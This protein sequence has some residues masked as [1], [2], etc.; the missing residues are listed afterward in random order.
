MQVV[1]C[2]ELSSPRSGNNGVPEASVLKPLLFLI[3]ITHVSA[4][5]YITCQ[6]RIFGDDLKLYLHKN[7]NPNIDS[8]LC[9]ILNFPTNINNLFCMASFWWLII[10]IVFQF[11]GSAVSDHHI[12][13]YHLN[14]SPLPFASSLCNLGILWQLISFWNFIPISERG[15]S[16]SRG[17]RFQCVE[18]HCLLITKL[19]V[20]LVH[21]AHLGCAWLN[22]CEVWRIKSV[23]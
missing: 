19:H 15:C 5:I 18:L 7:S 6:Y 9:D 13:R 1:V 21:Y 20:F 2:E 4:D 23:L 10:I 3:Y 14:G 8:L 22:R 11:N 12:L 17:T 16:E